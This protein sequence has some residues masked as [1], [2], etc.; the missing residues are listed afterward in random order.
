MLAYAT[1]SWP[2]QSAFL[3]LTSLVHSRRC[4]PGRSLSLKLL[5]QLREQGARV[6]LP[7]GAAG[8]GSGKEGGKEVA[9]AAGGGGAGSGR[10]FREVHLG[11]PIRW[12]RWAGARSGSLGRS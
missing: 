6:G 3:C 1:L 5:Q 8:A 10:T 2:V 11:E 4:L 12:V 9:G 7:A